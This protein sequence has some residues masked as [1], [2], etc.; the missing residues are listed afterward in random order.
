MKARN[1]GH[2]HHL[3]FPQP[4]YPAIDDELRVPWRSSSLPIQLLPQ[5][6]HSISSPLASNSEWG[7]FLLSNSSLFQSLPPIRAPKKAV[8]PITCQVESK[9]LQGFPKV[10]SI[11]LGTPPPIALLRVPPDASKV[12]H[13]V[14]R[15]THTTSNCRQLLLMPL[16]LRNPHPLPASSSRPISNVS[17]I[18]NP[19]RIPTPH[20]SFL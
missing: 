19:S 13:S 15:D 9:D 2:F 1:H 4:S 10:T 20:V 11:L 14:S 12:D 5:I 18:K 8:A 17:Q 7:A 16:L 6:K 3:S